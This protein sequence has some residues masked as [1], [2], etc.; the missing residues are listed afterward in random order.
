MNTQLKF[1]S[2]EV[3]HDNNS[4]LPGMTEVITNHAGVKLP[5]NSTIYVRL[6]PIDTCPSVANAKNKLPSAKVL[7]VHHYYGMRPRKTSLYAFFQQRDWTAY[8]GMAN[9]A[10][11]FAIAGRNLSS[12][13]WSLAVN[14]LVFNIALLSLTR[15]SQKRYIQEQKIGDELK[16]TVGSISCVFADS[17]PSK[18]HF[19]PGR[20]NAP[21]LPSPPAF[22]PEHQH[23]HCGGVHTAWR[24]CWC[25]G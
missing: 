12:K 24:D 6:S 9:E 19:V 25:Q 20:T 8:L 10:K 3:S 23:E 21:S 4:P 13:S 5:V 16:A 2:K 11:G 15:H 7:K 18:V 14:L 1:S 17:Q 22:G